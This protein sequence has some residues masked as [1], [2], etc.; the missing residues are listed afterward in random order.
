M[1][2]LLVLVF[3]FFLAG[4]I[5]LGVRSPLKKR[6]RE[7]YLQDLAKFL[8]GELEPIEE[9]AL[10][11]SFRVRF[12]FSGEEFVYEDTEELGFKSKIYKGYLKIKTPSKLTLTFTEKKR[13]TKIRTDIFIASEISTQQL[14]KHIR[15]NVPDHLKDFKV[16]TNDSL[17]ANKLLEDKKISNIFK[18]FKNI[19][20][21]GYPFSSIGIIDGAVILEFFSDR[22]FS[23]NLASLW[24]DVASIENYL[25]KLMVIVRKLKEGA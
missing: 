14:E 4:I 8:E 19:N 13:S 2:G 7:G 22:A 21:R 6:T 5:L 23:P 11:N 16:F 17:E 20:S 1:N 3:M 15:P 24:S 9:G 12:K 10:D 18:Q 25:N